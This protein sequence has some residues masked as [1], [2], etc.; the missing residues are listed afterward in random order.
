MGGKSE[1]EELLEFLA[2]SKRLDI[3]MV[4]LDQVLGLTGS[5]DG[6]KA[7]KPHLEPLAKTLCSL[8]KNFCLFLPDH[9]AAGS[10]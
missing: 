5:S 1:F 9:S 10:Q 2:D 7:I 4:A 6:L 3:Q 8:L